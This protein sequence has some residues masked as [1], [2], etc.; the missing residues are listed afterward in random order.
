MLV[1]GIAVTELH[2]AALFEA[3]IETTTGPSV[4]AT[5]GPWMC[6]AV[7]AP[8][9]HRAETPPKTVILGEVCGSPSARLMMK[10][11]EGLPEVFEA[12]PLAAEPVA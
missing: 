9:N 7:T 12:E 4:P 11:P 3:Q 8:L 6:A 2:C 5:A 1:P 10:I